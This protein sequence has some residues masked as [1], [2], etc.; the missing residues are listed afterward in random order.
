MLQFFLLLTFSRIIAAIFL[1]YMLIP[2][3][4][5]SFYAVHLRIFGMFGVDVFNTFQPSLLFFVLFHAGC[6]QCVH[7]KR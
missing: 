2:S 6:S 3:L 5:I 4:W 7:L 1:I